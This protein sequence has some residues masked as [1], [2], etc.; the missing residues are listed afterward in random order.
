MNRPLSLGLRGRL[1]LLL[2]SAFAVLAVLAALHLA[3]ESER[4]I[5]SETAELVANVR[6][7]ATRQ[8]ALVERAD[9][10]VNGLMAAPEQAQIANRESC[11]SFL[12]AHIAREPAFVQL[13]ESSPTGE[14]ICAAVRPRPGHNV[15]QRTFFQQT[16]KASEMVV[17]DVDIGETVGGPIIVFGKIVPGAGERPVAALF[18]VL[19]LDWLK[20]ELA[21]IRLPQSV[22]LWVVDAHGGIIAHYPDAPSQTGPGKTG[23]QDPNLQQTLAAGD[24]GAVE[25]IDE[26]GRRLLLAHAPL[27]T[28]ASG[29]N[30]SL[31]LSIPKA[32]LEGPARSDALTTFGMMLAVLVATVAG[33]LVGANRLLLSPISQLLQAASRLQAGDLTARSGLAHA[34]D[35]I[36]RLAATLDQTAAA[37]EDRE[38]QVV[39]ANLALQH[40]NQA[41]EEKVEA[42]TQQMREAADAREQAETRLAQGEKLRAVGQLTAGIA[43]DFN[44]LLTVVLGS[45]Q[46]L[47]KRVPHTDAR[48]V[49]LI[50]NAFQAGERGAVLTHRLLAFGRRQDLRPA[51]VDLAIL[52][53]GMSG[54][55][56]SSIGTSVQMDINI[57]PALPRAFVDANQ[58]EMAL[59]NLAVN[60]RDAM[61]GTGHLAI[62]AREEKPRADGTTE[63]FVVLSV[64]DTGT[65]M[66]ADTLARA[67]EPFFTSKG[68]GKGTGLGLSMVHGLAAQSGGKL[69]LRSA[70]GE[71]TTAELWLPCVDAARVAERSPVVAEAR[72]YAKPVGRLTVL[73]VDDDALVLSSTAAMLEDLGHI[74]VE[75]ASGRQALEIIGAAAHIDLVV[76]D[77]SMPGMTGVELA[78]RLRQ[79]RP[80]LPVLLATGYAER[81]DVLDA[82]YIVL[83]KPFEQAALLQAL[84]DCMSAANSGEKILPFPMAI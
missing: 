22:S 37:I 3:R 75:T 83:A 7:I 58:L 18:L 55:L 51:S 36:G 34:D 45:L 47:R 10:I 48:A 84:R 82:G 59:I 66:D 78:A 11:Q 56:A 44:N 42:R 29:S 20:R 70:P 68:V 19:R 79:Q 46:L 8:E 35:E 33:V 5:S 73:V 40:L 25:S 69:V 60:A 23:L 16:M 24:T 54:L 41:L 39:D 6:L 15:A 65:G 49:R 28:T 74:P 63:S 26:D 31:L 80:G 57:P 30:Y 21:D 77:Q 81:S 38:R 53:P 17:A 14:H 50:D 13:A 62:R 67:T 76:T 61:A 4:H 43:H 12:A 64:T 27:L 32:V 71:G 72:R 2:V 9:A 52:V 1:I